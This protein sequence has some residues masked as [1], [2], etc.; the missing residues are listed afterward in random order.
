MYAIQFQF[1]WTG[2]ITDNLHVSEHKTW[3]TVG[4]W[5]MSG[6]YAY[7]YHL[8]YQRDVSDSLEPSLATL[9]Y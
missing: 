7:L 1:I 9:S 2:K 8:D 4:D 6:D 3:L 5:W